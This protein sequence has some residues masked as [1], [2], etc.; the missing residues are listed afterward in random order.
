MELN[1]IYHGDCQE[2]IKE[3]P[4]KSIDCICT[5]PPY[6]YLKNQKLEREF[7]EENLFKEF[8]RILK[9]NGFIVL[10]GRGVSFYRWNTQLASSGFKF[11]EEIV[12]DKQYSSSP[13]LPISRMHENVSI[14]SINGSINR[15]YIPYIEAK[16]YD[17]NSICADVKRLIGI[18]GNNKDLEKV[19]EFLKSGNPY[20][21]EV[22]DA[23]ST[24]IGANSTK[25]VNVPS[26][27][28]KM[29]QNGQLEKDVIRIPHDRYTRI[30][31]TQKPVRLLE[32]LLALVRPSDVDRPVVLDPFAGS[33]SVA[34]AA[35]NTG[36]DYLCMEIDE[37][38]YNAGKSNVEKY[39]AAGV[40][41]RLF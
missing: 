35:L 39:V 22:R 1:K 14:Y 21:K 28:M 38:Y 5:D 37:E 20:T 36:W 13:V 29:F 4:D 6:L 30:H 12:W 2:L 34:I 10:F 15:C 17:V 40:Q 41:Q 18:L 31:P 9:P 33:C 7:D 11:K 24:T 23:S 32:R 19:K 8:A 16:N 3:I 27:V 26:M 25:K